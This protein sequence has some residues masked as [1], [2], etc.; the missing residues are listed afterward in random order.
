MGNLHYFLGLEITKDD[1]R[2][3]VTQ[4]KYIQDL[5]IKFNMEEASSCPTP[6]VT[7]KQIV[8]EEGEVL[9]NPTMFRKLIGAL[10][11]VTNTRL[12]IV[13]LVNKLRRFLNSLTLKHLQVAKR[14][15]RYLKGTIDFALRFKPI[16]QLSLTGYCDAYWAVSHED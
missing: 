6:M 10:Q 15:L 14:I 13:F 9:Q 3:F 1:T 4:K 7:G 5:L 16:A 2:L 12:G 8:A 11:Y